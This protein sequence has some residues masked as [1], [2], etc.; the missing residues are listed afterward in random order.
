MAI[1]PQKA[2]WQLIS[3]VTVLLALPREELAGPLLEVLAS[4]GGSPNQPPRPAEFIGALYYQQPNPKYPR[5]HQREVERAISEAWGWLEREGLI[6]VDWTNINDDSYY[7][8]V[9]GRAVT[10]KDQFEVYRTASKLP[11]ELLHPK[12]QD[13]VWLNFIRGKFDT[14]IFEAYREVEIAVRDVGGF[15]AGDIGTKLMRRAF[16][17]ENGPLRIPDHEDS[18]REGL[19]HLFAGAYGSYKNPPSH[20]R[21]GLDDPLDAIGMIMLAS[22]LLR[23][24]DAR[25]ELTKLTK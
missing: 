2:I 7:V 19:A 5:E 21:P 17:P 1:Q 13:D 15:V 16:D 9:R 14:A 24:V 6:A 10:G 4:Y 3:D 18:E 25:R 20:R 23:I 11:R 12:L 22:H 8:T